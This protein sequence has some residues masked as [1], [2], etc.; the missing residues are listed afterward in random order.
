[1]RQYVMSYKKPMSLQLLSQYILA[2]SGNMTVRKI[3]KAKTV[4][5]DIFGINI[6]LI[7]DWKKL[8]REVAL[9]HEMPERPFI[10]DVASYEATDDIIK[11]Y[12]N[13]IDCIS[14]RL[15][16]DFDS[17]LNHAVYHEFG[18]AKEARV[19]E[20]YGLYPYYIKLLPG[21]QPC[22]SAVGEYCIEKELQSRKIVNPFSQFRVR[23]LMRYDKSTWLTEEKRRTFLWDCLIL[24]PMD[25]VYYVN[26]GLSRSEREI[27]EQFHRDLHPQEWEFALEAMN[28]LEFGKPAEY[29]CVVTNLFKRFFDIDVSLTTISTDEFLRGRRG[30][31]RLWRKNRYHIIDFVPSR[32]TWGKLLGNVKL[33]G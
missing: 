26:G 7:I 16:L 31:H 29:I 18:H 20:E 14:K 12:P 21:F 10:I 11:L 17:I 9:A 32:G 19:F 25:V 22:L 24:L 28:S 1:M 6:P 2:I 30:H 13:Y 23:T 27:I 5:S 15:D 33:P 3:L 8:P 4:A